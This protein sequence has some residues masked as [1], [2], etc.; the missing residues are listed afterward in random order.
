M[1]VLLVGNYLPDRQESMLRYLQMVRGGLECA[2][3]S[4]DVAIPRQV[5]NSR[6]APPNGWSKWLGYLDK[7]ILGTQQMRRL[8][9]TADIVH[10]CDH[11]NATYVRLSAAKPHVVTCHDLLAVRGALGEETDCPASLTGKLLQRAILR[12]L[13]R[14]DAIACVSKLTLCDAE[15]LLP[16]YAGSLKYVPNALNHPYRR[17]DRAE[18]RSR[19]ACIPALSDGRPYILNIGSNLR[20]KN[21]ES[22]IDALGAIRG[23]WSNLLVFAGANL[24][25]QLR[26]R[27]A[28]L[29][30]LERIIEVPGPDNSLLEALYGGATALV[31]PSRFEGFGWPVVEAQACGCPVICS[32]REPLLEVAGGAAIHCSADDHLGVGKAIL[33][34]SGNEV[35]RANLI[36]L[37]L[38]NVRRYDVDVMI[39]RLVEIYETILRKK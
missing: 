25:P 27:A 11:S 3:M 13:S 33:E 21:R 14:A 9:K 22:V 24:T 37:G 7:Y 12:G 28:R 18:V 4:V 19:L 38:E 29:G 32:D 30:V 6:C 15:R 10:I 35:R 34:L 1:K 36:A 20:R 16:G 39:S 5:L 17:I 2:G 23:E 26:E 8:S 31:F